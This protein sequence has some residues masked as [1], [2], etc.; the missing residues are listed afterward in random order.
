MSDVF[1]CPS[2]GAPA[3]PK[4]PSCGYCAAKLEPVRCPWCFEW[5]GARRDCGR[6]GARAM[7]PG[8]DETVL[9]CPCGQT[10]HSRELGAA[11]LSGCASCA[12]V[13][14]DAASFKSI[15]ADRSTQAAYMGEGSVLARPS[16]S[17]PSREEIKY[18]PCPL[19]RELMNRIN[20]AG[21]SGVV[22]DL[23]KPHGVWFD[24]DE[25]RRI[26][27]FIR[28]GGLDVA[29]AKEITLLELERRRLENVERDTLRP[30]AG[31]P[32]WRRPGHVTAASG[33]LKHLLGI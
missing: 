2:C 25:L 22:L 8:Q 27:E 29:R 21:C 16:Q 30:V 33:L 23:C 7:P 12:G 10:L 31:L 26:V 3:D 13:W 20:F 9:T 32:P 5:I 18:R 14:A 28:A 1:R 6:C 4:A 19:C 17:D 15:C 11:R 24:P